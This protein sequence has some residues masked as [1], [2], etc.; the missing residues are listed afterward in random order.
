MYSYH[1]YCWCVYTVQRIPQNYIKWSYPIIIICLHEWLIYSSKVITASVLCKFWQIAHRMMDNLI[2]WFEE[3]L[4]LIID[5]SCGSWTSVLLH[6]FYH[7]R[8]PSLSFRIFT[9]LGSWLGSFFGYEIIL[10]E[11]VFSH[12]ASFPRVALVYWPIWKKIHKHKNKQWQ[13]NSNQ[14]LPASKQPLRN[15]MI[16][17]VLICNQSLFFVV[18]VLF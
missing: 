7:W 8:Y 17:T 6:L 11:I 10:R 4:F 16:D 5:F 9:L 3:R 15:N 14:W 12:A 2:P 1:L 13:Q 18:V